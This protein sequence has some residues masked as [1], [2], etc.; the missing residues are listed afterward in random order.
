MPVLSAMSVVPTASI[1]HPSVTAQAQEPIA[2]YRPASTNTTA[3]VV[4][5]L[6]LL[7]VSAVAIYWFFRRRHLSPPNEHVSSSM[8]LA[9][10]FT[11]LASPQKR[12]KVKVVEIKTREVK[13]PEMRIAGRERKE[14][15]KGRK[16]PPVIDLRAAI[17]AVRALYTC[18][19]LLMYI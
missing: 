10:W 11:N 16:A 2:I 13:Q 18:W 12:S 4:P 3:I 5:L 7:V 19:P 9:D 8:R 17:Q 14:S 6:V 1:R 15:K